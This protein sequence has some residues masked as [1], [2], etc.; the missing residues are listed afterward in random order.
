MIR[1]PL[2]TASLLAIAISLAGCG[3]GKDKA[4][5]P[6]APA[7]ASTT[8]PAAAPAGQVD[9]AAAK[10]VVAHYADMVF[11]V[12]SDAESTAKTL[13]T[14]IDTFL[15]NPNDE[16]LK[17][18]RTAWIAARVPYLQSEVFRFGNTIIDDWEGQVN[19]W[20]LDEG[21]ID[22]V[23]KSYEH[24]L[25]NPGANANI[26][27]NNEIQVGEDKVDV[28]EITPEKLASLNELG[29][30][31]ANVA[32]GYHAIEF[33]LWGQDLNGTGPGAGNRPASDYMTGDGATGGHN[34]RRRTYLRAVTQ[35][36]VSDLQEM[37]DNWKPN[38]EDNYRATLESEPGTDGL[39][40]MLFGM[41]SLSLGELAGE[42]MKVSLE[43]NSPEDEQDCFS[44]NTHYSHFYDAKGI[45]NVYL[46][47]YTRVDGTKLTGASLSSLVAKVDPAADAALKA[48][49]AATEAKIQV[50][51]DHAN[52]GEHYDQLIAADNEK[53][54][55]IVR[56]SIAALVK[57]TGSIEAAAGKLG[58]SDLNPDS[59]D[60]EF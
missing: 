21:L 60:H 33:L 51:V 24:A 45:R 20:P 4:A 35:L 37:V 16:T 23:D 32:T 11:A 53:G 17:A 25:G 44:D 59:A 58:I 28:K 46:G 19:A 29:G 38:V 57:Q 5:A 49:L 12:Y 27:A 39:R 47:E 55:Q 3:E 50:M 8:A 18:A 2:A 9:E 31:E 30:S 22:Y 1:M 36:L 14:A 41:G 7:A 52:N 54:N 10:A 34:E 15:A 13:Q 40:K 48:D 43:A 56:D 6:Q 26:I 42:R